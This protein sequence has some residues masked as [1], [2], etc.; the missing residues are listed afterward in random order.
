[1]IKIYMRRCTSISENKFRSMP[2]RFTVEVIHLI[3]QMMEYC[4]AR[5]GDLHMNFIDFEKAYGKVSK[6]VLR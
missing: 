2:K 4:R 6:Q 5:K 3:R 1:M